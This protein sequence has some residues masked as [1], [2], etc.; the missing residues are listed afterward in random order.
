MHMKR[1][2]MFV[3]MLYIWSTFDIRIM[4]TFGSFATVPAWMYLKAEHQN[5]IIA[6]ITVTGWVVYRVSSNVFKQLKFI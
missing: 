4:Y 6:L 5:T 1:A 3:Y 2:C